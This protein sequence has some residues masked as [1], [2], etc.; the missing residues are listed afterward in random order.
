VRSPPFP[1]QGDDSRNIACAGPSGAAKNCE[2]PHAIQ[3]CGPDKFTEWAKNAP[4]KMEAG[5]TARQTDRQAERDRVTDTEVQPRN[6]PT[7]GP[8]HRVPSATEVPRTGHSP[9]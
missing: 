1:N 6:P 2:S 7:L 3:K 4:P 8:Q 9:Q 5:Q